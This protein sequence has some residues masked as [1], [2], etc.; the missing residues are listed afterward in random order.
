MR[1][2]KAMGVFASLLAMLAS[3]Q[4]RWKFFGHAAQPADG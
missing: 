4:L 3:I 1:L 2:P